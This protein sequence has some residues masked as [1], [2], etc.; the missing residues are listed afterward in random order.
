MAHI[1]SSCDT[2]WK[3]PHIGEIMTR[4][5]GRSLLWDPENHATIAEGPAVPSG[6]AILAS[7]LHR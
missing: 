6:Q 5:L 2:D 4:L 3:F 7:I 1:A